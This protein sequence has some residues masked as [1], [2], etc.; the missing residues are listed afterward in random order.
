MPRYGKIGLLRRQVVEQNI[1]YDFIH[2]LR[3]KD[4][5][6]SP[7]AYMGINIFLYT[8]E[9]Q[10]WLFLVDET[11]HFNSS[12]AICF[13]KKKMVLIMNKYCV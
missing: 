9:T 7:R 11:F 2:A 10:Q 3:K 13:A 4:K 5:H 6:M 12:L 1:L 8:Q